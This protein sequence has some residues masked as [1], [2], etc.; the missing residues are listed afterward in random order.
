MLL[1]VPPRTQNTTILDP[2]PV[3][4]EH[5]TIPRGKITPPQRSVT[6]NKHFTSLDTRRQKE[7]QHAQEHTTPQPDN[8]TTNHARPH[9][10]TPSHRT[11][12][13]PPH[14]GT[15]QEK[16]ER[17][18]KPREA[19]LEQLHVRW[20]VRHD[21]ECKPSGASALQARHRRDY[22]L[23]L[24]V[25]VS[26]GIPPLRRITGEHISPIGGSVGREQGRRW[27]GERRYGRGRAGRREEGVP[28]VRDV[29]HD[30]Q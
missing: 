1:P 24:R 6:L 25:E 10:S 8:T 9:Q 19:P 11:Q 30:T 23:V 20:P 26:L 3:Y 4:Y 13:T 16:I 2:K 14:P 21:Q 15:H 12:P 27:R 18:V 7:A 29:E 22:L 5:S 17:A 28:D